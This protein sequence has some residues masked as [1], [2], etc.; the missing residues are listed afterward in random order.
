MNWLNKLERRFGKYYIHNLMGIITAGSAASFILTYIFGS[1]FLSMFAL[2]PSKIL[3]GQVWRLVTFIF[4]TPGESILFVITIYFYYMAGSSLENVWG[5]FKFNVYYFVGIISTIIVAF[6]NL[7]LLNKGIGLNVEN[8]QN[9]YNNIYLAATLMNLSL[10]LAYAKIYPDAQILLF[11]ILPV[12]IKYLGYLNWFIIIANFIKCLVKVDIGGALFTIVPVI[13]Y[14]LFFLKSNYR[15]TKMRTGS[16]IRMKDYKKKINSTKKSY[17]HK[18]ETCGIT[19]VNDPDM[20]FRYCSKCNGKHC[21]C[22]KH[23]LDH[24][25]VE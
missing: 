11:F 3:E 15:Q 13:S 18:C 19:N 2:D 20:E 21:Y 9:Y 12:K 24:I 23:I 1:G 4:V 14:L 25:H 8:I 7:F 22:A 16:V 17:I 6:I 10:F 5:G